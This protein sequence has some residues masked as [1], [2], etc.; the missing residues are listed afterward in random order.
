MRDEYFDYFI[1]K[2]GEATSRVAVSSA[3]ISKW[4]G[5]LPDQL[6]RYWEEEGWCSYANGLLWTVD[7]EYYEDLV[8][9][10]LADTVLEQVDSFHAFARSAFGDLYLCGEHS[11]AS[12]TICCQLNAISVLGSAPRAKSSEKR[13][14][15]IQSFFAASALTDFDLND[16]NGHPLF[17]RALGKLGSLDIDE[18]YGFEPALVLGGAIRLE[19]LSKLDT[20]VHLTILR[21]LAAPQLPFTAADIEQLLNQPK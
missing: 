21:Q 2:F 10:W 15:S 8:D 19:N 3:A 18:T 9:E 16:D 14:A 11:G 4:R 6:L 5:R 13:D 20:D 12:V 17:A 1:G 7:P